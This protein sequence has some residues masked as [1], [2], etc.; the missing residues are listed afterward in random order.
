MRQSRGDSGWEEQR[1]P[2]RPPPLPSLPTGRVPQSWRGL[3]SLV[4]IQQTPLQE[5]NTQTR[6]HFLFSLPGDPVL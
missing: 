1:E 3:P 5:E 2:E 4:C 6:K